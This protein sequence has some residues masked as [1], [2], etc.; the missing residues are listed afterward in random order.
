MLRRTTVSIAA[1]LLVNSVIFSVY[2]W[3]N[4]GFSDDPYN[5]DYGTHD[6]I[7]QHALDWVPLEE[8]QFILDNLAI[9]L[10]GTELPD[11]NV[12]PD[13]IGDTVKHHV[14]YFANG[15]LQEDDSAVRAQQEYDLAVAYFKSGELVNATKRLGVMSHYICDVAAFGHVMGAETEWGGETHHDDYETYVNART[16]IYLDEFNTFLGFDG[17]LS[18][19]SAYNATLT[20]AYDT[21][22]DVDG[23][24]TC[25]WMDQNYNWSNPTFEN[26]CGESLNLAVNFIAD[27]LHTFYLETAGSAHFINVPFHYQG[28]NYYCGPACL[29]MVFDYYGEDINQTE[30]ADVARTFPY[31]TYTDELLRSAHFSNMSVSMGNEIPDSN[32]AGYSLRKL[33]YAAFETYSMSLEQLKSYVDQ[34]RPLILLMLYE[35]GSI[36][37]HYRV[38]TGYNETH[39]F[40]HDPWNKPL[41]GETYGGSNIVFNNTEFLELWMYSGN[42][43]LYVSPWTVNVSAPSYIEPEASFQINVTITYPEPLLNALSNYSASVCNA[44]ITLPQNMSLAMGEFQKKTFSP[45]I[46]EA[47]AN[48][49]VSW[50]LTAESL[51]T[52]TIN[53]E[54]EGLVSGSVWEHG[55]YPAYDYSDKI[56][57]VASFRIESKED[58]SPPTIGVP[59]RIPEG[60]VQPFQGVKVSVN[61]TDQE[62]GVKNATLS[63]T[64]DNGT[65]WQNK[66]MDRNAST[67]LFEVTIPGQEAGTLVRFKIF[68][69]DWVGNN[70]TKDGIEAYCVYQVIPEFLSGTILLIFTIPTVLVAIYFVKKKGRHKTRNAA[71]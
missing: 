70:A 22:F 47:G 49:T 9:Y 24:L 52:Y 17:V 67:N 71:E 14:Y 16:N 10:Y 12:A 15:S 54:V 55:E 48:A 58:D 65:S 39:V 41:W 50:T 38:V 40:V 45:G 11:N 32:I 69:Y 64:I 63:Y 18:D 1:F 30:I 60:E 66:T 53:V 56:G 61:I 25:V 34:D 27:V 44:T 19:I 13:H 59:S 2:S 42:W 20:L 35:V 26:R 4:G 5:P 8:K 28:T 33:G 37:G 7:A 62:S 57:V 6:W 36:Y 23:E 51:G 68:A 3:G 21:T 43:A 46:F 29:E 31:V